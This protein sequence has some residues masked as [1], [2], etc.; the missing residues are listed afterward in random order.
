MSQGAH[1]SQGKPSSEFERHRR[2][3][4][5]CAESLAWTRKQQHCPGVSVLPQV[6]RQ[7]SSLE[8][9]DGYA[10]RLSEPNAM[11]VGHEVER[12]A[13]GHDYLRGAG[14]CHDQYLCRVDVHQHGLPA[15][16]KR[17]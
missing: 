12:Q 4:A 7:V 11:R 1:D 6:L 16:I 5:I 13:T 2:C 9:V 3:P 14:G 15:R 17:G 8:E 10:K